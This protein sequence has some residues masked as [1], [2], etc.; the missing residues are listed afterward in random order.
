[1][2]LKEVQYKNYFCKSKLFERAWNCFLFQDQGD[3]M[4]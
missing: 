2:I 3:Q 1:M 4:A